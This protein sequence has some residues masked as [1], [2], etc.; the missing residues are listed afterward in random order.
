MEEENNMKKPLVFVLLLFLLTAACT[1]TASPT[2]AAP[3]ATQAV[4]LPTEVPPTV[5][6]TEPPTAVT[7]APKAEPVL[8]VTGPGGTKQL[9]MADVQALPAVEG[10]AGIKTSTGK[11]T[12]P[13]LFKGV[14]ITELANLVGGLDPSMGINV[15]AE[16]GYAMTLSYDQ[17]TNGDFVAYDPGTGDEKKEKEPLQVIIAYAN[18]GQP[19]PKDSDGNFRLVIVTPKNDQVTD[20][21]WSVKWVNKIELKP[22]GKEWSLT[23]SGVITDVI[24]RNSFQS[25][26]APGCHQASWTDD[27]AQK[28]VGVPLWLLVGRADDEIRHDGPAFYEALAKAG[29]RIE[30]IATD[31]Y[32]VTLDS[33]RVMRNNDMIM[34]FQVN[35]TPLP[36]KYFPLRLVGMDVGKKEGVGAVAEIKLIIDPEVAAKVGK[37]APQ[38][39]ITPTVSAPTEVPAATEVPTA[40][41]AAVQPAAIEGDLV[42]TGLVEKELVLKESDLRA[43][44]VAKI[45]AEHPKKGKEDYEGVRL[46]LLFEQAKIKPEATKIVF[47]AVDGFV[48]ELNLADVKGSA[49]CMVAFTNTPGKLKMVLPGLPSNA[50]VKDVVEIELK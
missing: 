1:P 35:D 16:D 11:I 26:T 2:P 23:V 8:E 37:E 10:Q 22:L 47:T 6:P 27:K 41:Q 9:T 20:G 43:M 13:S 34:A 17:V 42:I 39:E 4:E 49:D 5:A 48:A 21:H 46:S 40:T 28:W 25:C 32:S 12:P 15:V 38:T 18:N 50:W 36:D 29:Y 24:D 19:L 45:T 14:A 30:I 7:E 3:A 33:V 44:E 31:G